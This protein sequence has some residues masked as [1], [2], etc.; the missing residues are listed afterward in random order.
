MGYSCHG[1]AGPNE[2]SLYI[3][4][5]CEPEVPVNDLYFDSTEDALAV[6]DALEED[7]KKRQR[8]GEPER[9]YTLRMVSCYNFA[10]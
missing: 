7:D 9:S 2:S 4:E 8:D 10:Y 5:E 6:V 1:N 3:E